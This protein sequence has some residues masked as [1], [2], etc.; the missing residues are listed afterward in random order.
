VRLVTA[1]F[2]TLLTALAV[3]PLASAADVDAQDPSRWVRVRADDGEVNRL[4]LSRAGEVVTVADAGADLLAG[5]GC[6]QVGAHEVRC[7]IADGEARVDAS[8]G[9]GDDEATALGAIPVKLGGDAGHDV[10]SGGDGGGVLSGGEGDDVLSGGDADDRLDGGGG[11]DRLDGGP[12]LDSYDGGE[13][14][15]TIHARDGVRE[16]VACGGGQDVGEADPEDDVAADCEGV[17]TPLAPPSLVDTAAPPAPAPGRSVAA[18]VK[19]GT[20]LVRTPGASTFTPLDPTRPVPVGSTFDTRAG[21]LSLTAAAGTAGATQTADFRGGR[22][23]VGQAANAVVTALRMRGGSFAG[24]PRP[25]AR[26]AVARAASRRRVVRRLWGSGKGRF[27]TRGRSSSATV[28]GTTWE[29]VDRCDGTLTRVRSGV[30]VVESLRTG[31]TK[32][33]RAGDSLLVPRR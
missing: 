14:N 29:V 27:R 9:D 8:L 12:G 25:P 7:A 28:R 1:L 6:E 33:L 19:S 2:A 23:S 16:S 26:G 24:C 30:V 4:T 10:L 32:V 13:A 5:P 11:D 15:D 3:A 18:A 21:T 17:A 22:F 31:R 20:V